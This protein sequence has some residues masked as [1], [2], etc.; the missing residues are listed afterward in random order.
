[1]IAAISAV[2]AD[3]LAPRHAARR[4]LAFQVVQPVDHLMTLQYSSPLELTAPTPARARALR[5]FSSFATQD[6]LVGG[7]LLVLLGGVALGGG[8]RREAAMGC[9]AVD[10]VLFF[11]CMLIARSQVERFRVG[12]DV[13]YRVGLIGGL[14]ASFLQLHLILP[15]VSDRV[16]DG[17]LYR[18]DLAVFGFE[19]AQSWDRFVTPRTTEWFSFFYYSYF[20]LLCAYLLPM[21]LFE[22]RIRILSELSAGLLFVVCVGHCLYL[23]VPGRGPWAHLAGQFHHELQGGTWWPL[24]RKAVDSV[25]GSARKDIFPSLHTACPTFLTLFTFR[26]RAAAPYRYVWPVTA[27]FTSQIILATMFLR[28]HYLID[29]VAG[30]TLA[31]VA[32]VFAILIVPAEATLRARQGTGPVWRPLFGRARP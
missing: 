2:F 18:L 15:A 24:V 9:L 11:A 5:A 31:V 28:W 7:Y 32:F 13:L 16:L 25:D 29:V 22:R 21:A 23:A 14:I 6:C 17:A 4:L 30:L 19:P 26:N 8:P 20:F 3:A 12:A 27:F 10:V 1:V